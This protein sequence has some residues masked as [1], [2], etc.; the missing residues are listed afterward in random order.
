MN[1]SETAPQ[2]APLK[3]TASCQAKTEKICWIEVRQSCPANHQAELLHL[4]AEA[5][6]LLLRLQTCSKK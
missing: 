2:V 1:V 4:L 6:A 5:D 3:E